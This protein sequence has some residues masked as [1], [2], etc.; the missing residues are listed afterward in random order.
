MPIAHATNQAN[1]SSVQSKLCPH[2]YI[3]APTPQ[4]GPR[5]AGTPASIPDPVIN[6]G[7]TRQ[8][9]G[10]D[11]SVRKRC[12]TEERSDCRMI[13]YL[14]PND[15]GVL[16]VILG[17]RCERLGG[18]FLAK[19]PSGLSM[20]FASHRPSC[21]MRPAGRPPPSSE[22]LRRWS[23]GTTTR[24]VLMQRSPKL[25]KEARCEGFLS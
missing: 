14:A 7:Q 11:V 10:R 5:E 17:A 22:V 15:T 20:L 3:S 25:A 6:W 16:P 1:A 23:C 4:G 2:P 13:R 8:T 18:R 24:I 19:L 9:Q 12:S 21:P